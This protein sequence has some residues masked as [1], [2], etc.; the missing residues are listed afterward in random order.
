MSHQYNVNNK[1]DSTLTVSERNP[2]NVA[3]SKEE[4]V[5]SNEV[6]QFA[7]RNDTSG[8]SM[9]TEVGESGDKVWQSTTEDRT[10]DVGDEG[11]QSHQQQ[12]RD[13]PC[14]RE[15]ERICRVW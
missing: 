10:G 3:G 8:W 2:P 15:V 12:D 11:V 1:V 13:L 9:L 7:E 14:I 4:V 6:S 5:H